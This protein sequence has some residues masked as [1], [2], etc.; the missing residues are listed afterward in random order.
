[1]SSDQLLDPNSYWARKVSRRRILRVGAGLGFAAAIGGLAIGCGDDDDDDAPSTG[2]TD[3]GE[4][5]AGGGETIKVGILHSLSGT[6]SISE[7]SVK[8][9]EVLALEEINAAGGVMGK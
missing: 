3:G 8:D 9:A 5:P 7:V 1:M 2:A 4:E 6:M